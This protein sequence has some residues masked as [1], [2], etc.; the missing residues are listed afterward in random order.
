MRI[1]VMALGVPFTYP[2]VVHD[3]NIQCRSQ[4]G[5]TTGPWSILLITHMHL[6]HQAR[7]TV[8]SV[9]SQGGGEH[10]HFYLVGWKARMNLGERRGHIAL[11]GAR[12]CPTGAEAQRSRRPAWVLC[13]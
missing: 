1:M 9:P 12:P 3:L 13:S 8:T 6:H 2:H 5:F 10:K 11:R 7:R 4:G